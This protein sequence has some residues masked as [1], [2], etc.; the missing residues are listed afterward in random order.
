MGGKI[1]Q[2]GVNALSTPRMPKPAYLYMLKKVHDILDG[3]RG[4]ERVR[5]HKTPIPA[6]GKERFGDIDVIIF[7]TV[8]AEELKDGKPDFR[9]FLLQL[10][11][12]FGAVQKT[13]TTSDCSASYALPWPARYAVDRPEDESNLPE[14]LPGLSIDSQH[15]FIQVDVTV[16]HSRTLFDWQYMVNSHSGPFMFLGPSLHNVL[17]KGEPKGFY[18]RVQEMKDAGQKSGSYIHLTSNPKEMCEVVGWDYK[19]LT[20]PDGFTTS[21]ELFEFIASSRYF[22]PKAEKSDEDAYVEGSTEDSATASSAGSSEG[23]TKT[24]KR[25]RRE[26]LREWDKEFLP[27]TVG[28]PDYQRKIPDPSLVREEMFRRFP[29]ARE[30]Y[31]AKLDKFV[32]AKRDEK[33]RKAIKNVFPSRESKEGSE[34]DQNVHRFAAIG[35]KELLLGDTAGPDLVVT[36]KATKYPLPDLPNLDSRDASAGDIED[37]IK[38]HWKEVGHWKMWAVPGH[39]IPDHKANV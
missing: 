19:K 32:A 8:S 27:S 21:N 24:R 15:H 13:R 37:W 12:A 29:H 25:L 1:F 7:K 30:A 35:L 2:Q 38:E 3:L 23:N 26:P 17:L 28:N 16:T 34:V 6:P 18:L 9:P 4:S 22:L 14:M 20:N 33:V 5:A 11:K 39:A 31:Q 10:Q 36:S